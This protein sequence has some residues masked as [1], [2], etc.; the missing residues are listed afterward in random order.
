MLLLLCN[1]PRVNTE[2]ATPT[3]DGAK[4]ISASPISLT[5]KTLLIY[6]D[7][8][9]A[10]SGD[11]IGV[12]NTQRVIN[13]RDSGFLL[14]KIWGLCACV[15]KRSH[16]PHLRVYGRLGRSIFGCASC[17]C[18]GTPILLNLPPYEIGVS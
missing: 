16:T 3:R 10:K 4:E 12:L 5:T 9:P 1:P 18:A 14:S 15:Q 7:H 13:G 17:L 8:A 6:S 2:T 11:R